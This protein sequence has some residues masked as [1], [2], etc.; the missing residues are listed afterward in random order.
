MSTQ[1]TELENLP[2]PDGMDAA[3]WEE[4]KSA[5]RSQ[6]A[7]VK[8]V[9]AAPATPAS[10]AKLALDELTLTLSWGYACQGDYD[11]NREVNIADLSPLGSGFGTTTNGLGPFP[12]GSV[13]SMVDGD[14]NGELNI[15]DLSPIGSNFGRRVEKYNIY[16]SLSIDDL[17]ASNGGPVGSGAELLG[18][19][20]HNQATGIPSQGQLQ[21]SFQLENAAP[22]WF[23]FVRPADGNSEGTPSNVASFGAK[24]DNLAP[25]ASFT[26]E[27][28]SGDAPLVVSFDASGSSD[29][30]GVN[31]DI[32]DIV[33]FLWDF[34]GDGIVD[35]SS[36]APTTQHTYLQ[37]GQFNVTLTVFDSGAGQASLS[38][39]DPLPNEPPTAVLTAD[40]PIG[41]VPLSVV[42]DPTASSDTDGSIIVTEMDFDG[43]GNFDDFSTDPAESYTHLYETAGNF[44]AT[45]RVTDDRG[46][47]ATAVVLVQ[48]S[49]QGNLPPLPQFSFQPDSG[50]VPLEVEFDASASTDPDGTI[51]S[52]D[53]DFNN[54]GLVD[55]SSPDPVLQHVFTDAGTF[56]VRL[57]VTDDGGLSTSSIFTDPLEV[58]DPGNLAPLAVLSVE[59]TQA[60]FPTIV[61]LDPSASSDPDGTI[62][63]YEYDFDG[64]GDFEIS[65]NDDSVQQYP[66]YRTGSFSPVLRVT[67][68]DGAS[69]TDSDISVQPT[70]GWATVLVDTVPNP[71]DTSLAFVTSGINGLTRRFVVCY[72]DSVDGALRSSNAPAFLPT[73]W[74]TPVL[75]APASGD[76]VSLIEVDDRPAAFFTLPGG[77]GVGGVGY[78]RALDG[79][80]TGWGEPLAAATFG[81]AGADR[82]SAVVT[83]GNPGVVSCHGSSLLIRFIAATDA[84]GTAFAAPV[85]VFSGG[86]SAQVPGMRALVVDGNPAVFHL[87]APVFGDMEYRAATTAS[88]SSWPTEPRTVLQ[89]VKT[90]TQGYI[91]AATKLSNGFPMVA[92][93]DLGDAS[94]KVVLAI[95][96]VIDGSSWLI[97]EDP[98]DLP[99]L[100]GA[101]LSDFSLELLGDR[102]LMV[103][104]MRNQGNSALA[105]AIADD[106]S[107]LSWGD[108]EI[109][110]GTG[111]PGQSCSLVHNGTH[112]VVSHFDQATGELRIS[113]RPTSL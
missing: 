10:A 100:D 1:L 37:P 74:T 77:S 43:D 34:D 104:R 8:A 87:N 72:T 35:E 48:L 91:G 33:Q 30:D 65:V 109:L 3:R 80:G 26:A 40:Q 113:T 88:G 36:T 22:G 62:S 71:S 15:A 51:V 94:T 41:N 17:P 16:R 47:Q 92:F 21:F 90:G 55:D 108:T 13:E 84:T 42:F 70:E 81:A 19:L 29:L 75:A 31:G 96:T 64:D 23:Y 107:A 103:F 111:R 6:L 93:Q 79:K 102:P 24:P 106:A 83:A 68:N 67:D 54:D 78:V 97:I 60:G 4:L 45:L 20:P 9:L 63:Q 105:F 110:D 89:D 82:L 52:Y 112:F 39:A 12:P 58:S 11:Q 101:L 49:A 2:M 28:Q 61:S 32:S 86:S 7:G 57:T 50:E 18:S 14:S 66:F 25:L 27:P 69:A 98:V 38:I 44:S 46:A 73:G 76:A 56:I 85:D 95:A 59:V 53:W 5:M 99:F